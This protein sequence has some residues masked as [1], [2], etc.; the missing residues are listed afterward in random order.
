MDPNGVL[1]LPDQSYRTNGA[2]TGCLTSPEMTEEILAMFALE[3]GVDM[4]LFHLGPDGHR[5]K[6][7]K[8]DFDVSEERV[9]EFSDLTLIK[10]LQ[11]REDI[12]MKTVLEELSKLFGDKLGRHKVRFIDGRAYSVPVLSCTNRNGAK[13]V[14]GGRC[15][16]LIVLN[17]WNNR[18]HLLWKSVIGVIELKKADKNNTNM[19]PLTRTQVS[20]FLLC[21]CCHHDHDTS[22]TCHYPFPHCF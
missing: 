3:K 18:R 16:I 17:N 20:F 14:Y 11:A 15:D 5:V 12:S 4:D 7:R 21:I 13:I 10:A 9:K 22:L 19:K 2:T 8:F 6:A 1:K